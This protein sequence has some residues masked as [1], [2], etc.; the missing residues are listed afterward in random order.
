MPAVRVQCLSHMPQ[1]L[2]AMQAYV[3]ENRGWYPAGTVDEY[4]ARD[5]TWPAAEALPMRTPGTNAKAT[6]SAANQ[7]K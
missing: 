2:T 6:N 3:A 5:T 1:T 7:A 4:R